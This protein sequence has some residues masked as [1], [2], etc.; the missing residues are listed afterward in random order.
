M[1]IVALPLLRVAADEVYPPP[2]TVTDPLGTE[3]PLPPLTVTVT[4]RL[5]AVVMLL[6][7]VATATVGVTLVG[8]VTVTVD[9]PEALL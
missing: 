1:L 2:V 5:C 7:E 9:T 6:E 4:A 8:F 3:L